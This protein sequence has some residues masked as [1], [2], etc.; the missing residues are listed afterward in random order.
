MPKKLCINRVMVD[1]RFDLTKR[2]MPYEDEQ[3][4]YGLPHSFTQKQEK[5]FTTNV[6]MFNRFCI[7]NMK[8]KLHSRHFS[9]YKCKLDQHQSEQGHYNMI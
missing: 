2:N 9:P 6:V 1:Q 4:E 7:C 5:N 8:L 3:S